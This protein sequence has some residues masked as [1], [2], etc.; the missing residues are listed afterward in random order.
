MPVA[1]VTEIS[2]IKHTQ[3]DQ[4]LTSIHWH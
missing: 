2:I 4:N 3:I 1:M